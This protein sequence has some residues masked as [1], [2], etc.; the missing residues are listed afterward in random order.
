MIRTILIWVLATSPW[1]VLFGLFVWKIKP[2]WLCK[3]FDHKLGNS[4]VIFM[5]NGYAFG[6]T[7]CKRCGAYLNKFPQSIQEAMEQ[8]P[9]NGGGVSFTFDVPVNS[10][11]AYPYTGKVPENNSFE[12]R[13][14]A[15]E[16]NGRIFKGIS[17]IDLQEHYLCCIAEEEYELAKEIFAEANKRGI[18]LK[19]E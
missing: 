15:L 7:K 5:K 12:D 9:C 17:P 6:K 3:I 4:M 8:P 14:S 1:L 13:R 11:N 19:T 16:I 2:H 18:T 10:F